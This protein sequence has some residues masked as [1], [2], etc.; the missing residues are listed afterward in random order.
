M[1]SDRFG[2]VYNIGGGVRTSVNRVLEILRGFG[3]QFTIQYEE[4]QKG[5]VLHTYADISKARK[6]LGYSPKV[7]LEEG[8]KQQYEWQRSLGALS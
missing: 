7:S 1:K 4:Q 6:F 3:C 8:L 2:E 5:D